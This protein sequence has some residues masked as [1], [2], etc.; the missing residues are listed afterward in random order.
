MSYI[1]YIYFFL[2]DNTPAIWK[3]REVFASGDISNI[4][5]TIKLTEEGKNSIWYQFIL[6]KNSNKI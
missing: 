1:I 5:K 6:S 3:Y 4:L 2:I